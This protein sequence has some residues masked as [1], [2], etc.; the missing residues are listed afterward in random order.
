MLAFWGALRDIQKAAA[1]ETK[2]TSDFINIQEVFN[3]LIISP[4]QLGAT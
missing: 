2:E 4:L 3:P 1:R